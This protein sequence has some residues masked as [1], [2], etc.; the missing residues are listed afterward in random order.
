VWTWASFLLTIAFELWEGCLDDLVARGL[1]ASVVSV[2]DGHAGLWKAVE[3]VWP[4]AG[5]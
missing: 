1:R 4:D 2:I 5:V 3:F